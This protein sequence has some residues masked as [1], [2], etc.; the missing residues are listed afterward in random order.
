MFVKVS[1]DTLFHISYTKD[2]NLRYEVLNSLTAHRLPT[3]LKRQMHVNL[4]TYICIYIYMSDLENFCTTPKSG[5]H[6]VGFFS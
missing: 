6:Y 5:V 4:Y 3:W 1:I 2:I